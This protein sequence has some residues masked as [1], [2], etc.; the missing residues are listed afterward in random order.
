M[1]IELVLQTS[2]IAL[3]TQLS[4]AFWNYIDAGENDDDAAMAAAQ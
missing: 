3:A 2:A 1:L 4:G